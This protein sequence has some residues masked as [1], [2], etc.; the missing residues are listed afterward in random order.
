[1]T[2]K[3]S[4]AYNKAADKYGMQVAEVGK[5]FLER[6]RSGN[7]DELYDPDKSH[8]SAIGSEIAAR[9]ILERIN[10]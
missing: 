2:A 7:T 4:E 10:G 6:S 3:L 5:A 1:M 8:P 9:V